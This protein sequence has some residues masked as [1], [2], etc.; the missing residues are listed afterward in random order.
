MDWFA[1]RGF[2]TWTMDNEGYGRSDKH[3]AQEQ[4]FA[5]HHL[6]GHDVAPSRG[7]SHDRVEVR[8]DHDKCRVDANIGRRL[9]VGSPCERSVEPFPGSAT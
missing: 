2:D 7:A 6:R 9:R 3:R 4:Q 8:I 5:E 1:E